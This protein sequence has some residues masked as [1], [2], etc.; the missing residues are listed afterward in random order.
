[1]IINSKWFKVLLIALFSCGL[2]SSVA[3]AQEVDTLDDVKEKFAKDKTGTNPLNFTQ[4]LHKL[5]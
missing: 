5:C 2:Y 4:S 1:M 3:L